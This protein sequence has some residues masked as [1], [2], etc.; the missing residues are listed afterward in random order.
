MQL[1]LR[2]TVF[3]SC[4][5]AAC[6]F[7]PLVARRAPVQLLPSSHSVDDVID[8]A[9]ALTF[10]ADTANAAVIQDTVTAGRR[11]AIVR[12]AER[13]SPAVVSVTVTVREQVIPRTFMES[14]FIPPGTSQESQ[15]LGSGS[16]IDP[17]GLVL[18]NEHV[19][20]GATE[21]YVTLRDGR[22]F[23]ADLAGFDDVTDL[24]LLRLK[25]VT[26]SL[27][28]V[29]LGS[30]KDLLVGE[31]AIAIGNPFGYLLSNAEPTVTAGVISGLNRNIISSAENGDGEGGGYYLDMIQTDASINPGNSGGPLVN[32]LGQVIGVNSSIIS[33][34]GGSI[35][36]GFAIPIDRAKRIAADLLRDGK[37]RRVFTGVDLKDVAPD[38]SGRPARVVVVS[39]AQESPGAAAGIKPGMYV[40]SA[41]GRPIHTRFDWEAQLLDSRVGQSFPVVVSDGG[42]S[43]TITISPLD[44]PSL[45][46]GRV[47]ALDD[48]TL[49]TVTPAIR[50][51]RKLRSENGA[52]I[53]KVSDEARALG[54]RDGDLIVDINRNRIESAQQ[55]A[56]LLSR[57]RGTGV[58][59][60]TT[61]EREG[62]LGTISFNIGR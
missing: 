14:L 46:A 2:K 18:T 45:S 39:V 42:Q 54:F 21:I 40:L 53:V 48:F 13:V 28:V 4:A 32:A 9:S 27:P 16:I 7:A 33:G 43:R 26:G 41:S 11:T 62:Q 35:G 10:V 31:W 22:R 49:I 19:V 34:A 20:R 58:T 51:E 6:M 61:I 23:R 59:V 12:A 38:S 29:P 30:S 8:T 25:N 3:F 5:L 1:N 36:L 52:L 47:Q 44:L 17:R 55:A 24:A 15:G 57:F 37:V 56:S 50:A 60:R